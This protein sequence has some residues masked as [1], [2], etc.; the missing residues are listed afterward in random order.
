[1]LREALKEAARNAGA[2]FD[3]EGGVMVLGRAE[4]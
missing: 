2:A 1:M 3:V 4:G